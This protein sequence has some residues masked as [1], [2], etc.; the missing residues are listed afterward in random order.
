MPGARG[1][2]VNPYTASA[3]VLCVGFFWGPEVRS[4]SPYHFLADSAMALFKT[5]DPET[6][7]HYSIMAMK[8]GLAPLGHQTKTDRLASEVCGMRFS[9]PIGL[10]AGFDKQGDAVRPLIRMGFGFVEVGGVT[11]LPQDGNP[12]PRCFRLT[13]DKAIINR[14]GLN[15]EGAEVVA[16]RLKYTNSVR[17]CHKEGTDSKG[18]HVDGAIGVNLAK[19]TASDDP[20]ADFVTGME[21]L[22]PHVDFVV[23]N[24]SCPNVKWTDGMSKDAHGMESLVRAVTAARNDLGRLPGPALFIKLGP[25][26]DD[27]EKE[28]MAKLAIKC[29]VDG[30]VV[31]NTTKTRPASLMSEHKGEMGGLSG[32]PVKELA[33]QSVKDMYKLTNGKIPI[34]GVG[35]ISTAEDAYERIRAGASLVELYTALAYEGP[36]LP[37]R[38][39]I[40]LDALLERDGFNTVADAVGVDA[41]LA[42]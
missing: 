42:K 5:M 21:T 9:A 12:K 33:L 28:A 35:G 38:L 39:N 32:P 13:E 34:I 17:E 40:E 26:M 20:Y 23:L 3:G 8:Y 6:A 19:N 37:A 11:P 7:H 14:F 1:I 27:A 24:V 22:G 16:T 18:L 41:K 25:D 29:E 31:S 4:Y 10:A 15:S 2:G 36:S 30:L